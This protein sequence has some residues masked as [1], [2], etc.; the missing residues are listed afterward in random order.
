ML[1]TDPQ[2]NEIAYAVN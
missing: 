2:H 1:R